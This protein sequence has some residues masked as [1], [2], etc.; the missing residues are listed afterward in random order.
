[1]IVKVLIALTFYGKANLTC[2]FFSFV[3]TNSSKIQMMQNAVT[4][5][6]FPSPESILFSH[7]TYISRVI[8]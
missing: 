6:S 8:C 2:V 1:M 7:F 5:M 4:K 3:F